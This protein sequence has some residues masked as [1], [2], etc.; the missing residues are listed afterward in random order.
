MLKQ[1]GQHFCWFILH[2][3]EVK[4]TSKADLIFQ[5]HKVIHSYHAYLQLIKKN[6]SIYLNVK[7]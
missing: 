2:A 7:R 4:S 6:T 1:N 3:V 5:G